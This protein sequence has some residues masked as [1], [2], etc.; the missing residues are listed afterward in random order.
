M[1]NETR[2]LLECPMYDDLC[3]VIINLLPN[4]GFGLDIID[5][6]C[7]ILSNAKIQTDVGKCIFKTMDRRQS[8]LDLV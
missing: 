7:N 8:L 2:V 5:H 6:F 3:E 1:E 4:A